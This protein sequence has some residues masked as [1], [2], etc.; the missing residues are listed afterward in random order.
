MFTA[1]GTDFVF[2]LR[3]LRRAPGFAL[4]AILTLALGIGAGT[5]VY[6]LVDG[7]LLR[8]FPL[9][10]SEQL[11]AVHTVAR[12]PSGDI[13][14]RT[15]WPDLHVWQ[16]RNHSFSGMAGVFP[17]D[18]LV[19]RARG[20]IGAVIGVN[21]V[22]PNYFDVLGVQP[23]MGRSLAPSDEEAGHHIAII[24]FGLWRRLFGADPQVLG[25]RFL[26]SDEPYTIV[27]VMPRGFVE[28]Y[29]ET[30]DIWTSI[31]FLLEGTEPVG[32]KRNS[33]TAEVIG[34][35]KPGV[36]PEQ[37][38]ADLSSIQ[39]A[40]SQSYPEIRER[41]AVA[42]RPELED[43]TGEVRAPLYLLLASVLA[44]LLIVCTNVTGLILTRATKRGSEM[45]LR[46]ALGASHWRVWRQLLIESILLGI[47]GG[48][49]GA[50]LAWML[51][52]A[53]LPLIPDDVP[54]LAEVGLSWRVLCFAAAI[55]LV[56]VIAS[57]VS[58]ALRLTR[59]APL[60]ALREQGL[61][62][63]ARR[64]TRWL[65]NSLVA[66]QTAFGVALLIASGF[67]IRGFVNLRQV[68]TGFES[69]HVFTFN[70]A[71]TEVRYPHTTRVFFYNE[72]IAKLAAI[73]GVRSASSG[74]PLPLQYPSVN[75]TPTVEIDGRP[76][77]PGQ[78]FTTLVGVAEPG[79]F[80]TLGIPLRRGR[81]FTTADDNSHSPL[82]AVVNET[83]VRRYFPREDPIGRFIRPDIR[84]ARNQ[85]K[86]MDPKADEPRQIIGI[87]SDTQQ[88]SLTDPPE[89]I[90]YFPFAQANEL[91]RPR[92]VMRVTGD[93][94]KYAKP[95]ASVLQ[96]IDPTLFL[97]APWTGEIE[98]ERLTAAP[99]LETDLI[100]GFSA[101]ALFLTALG[102][103]SMLAA[104]I[105][106]R[107]REIGI[108]VSIGA[109]RGDVAWLI[110]ARAATLL[111]AGALVGGSIAAVVLRLIDTSDWAHQLLFGVSWV[112]PQTMGGIAAAFGLVALCGCL[113]PT[114]R[115]TRIDPARVL[116]DE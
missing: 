71:L 25:K 57:S 17:D 79:F 98:L 51:L 40:L 77:P 83:F 14:A 45:A 33:A 60:D 50:G 70:L 35:L 72:L 3:Q 66:V 95:A 43:V 104:A 106:A 61:H 105:N 5:A 37:A 30:A 41:N 80:E 111:A 28:P 62:T 114:W 84:N 81:L 48:L 32:K 6:S 27:G 78:D 63:T 26:I 2:A 102:L 36:T 52:R 20:A 74:Y 59:V 65:Q 91:Y 22:S 54:R 112:D 16:E 92:L 34:R 67:L 75:G 100:G 44:V 13:V 68:K 15:S 107:I 18:R 4:T 38:Q 88:G 1:L 11:V 10:H 89:P 58:P 110:L 55:T 56:C 109:T 9:P 108:R 29:E 53:A 82:V 76:N 94:M 96:G 90:A 31:A 103:Y 101:I 46:V 113:L 21:R 39:A 115:A 47:W 85:A 69:D 64:R 12:G 19:N 97:L 86:D 99:Q 49:V 93:P 87:I 42:V 8:P 24:S 73:P 7:V 23:I 116:R